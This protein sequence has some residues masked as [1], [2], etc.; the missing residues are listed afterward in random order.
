MKKEKFGFDP[1]GSW[2]EGLCVN[3]NKETKNH[4][5][6]WKYFLYPFLVPIFILLIPFFFIFLILY[7]AVEYKNVEDNWDEDKIKEYSNQ[8]NVPHE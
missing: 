1:D 4:D 2:E 6:I 7:S 8:L 3:R 5:S